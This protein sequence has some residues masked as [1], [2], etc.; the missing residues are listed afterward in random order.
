MSGHKFSYGYH[1][2]KLLCSIMVLV[3]VSLLGFSGG[4]QRSVVH[5]SQQAFP[6]ASKAHLRSGSEGN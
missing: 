2:K 4:S 1:P 3:N 5:H 6:V